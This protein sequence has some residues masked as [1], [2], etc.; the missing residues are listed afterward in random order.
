MTDQSDYDHLLW[1]CDFNLVRGEDSFLRAQWAARPFLWHIYPQADAAH[2]EKLTAFL[3]L[4]GHHLS[5]D[6]HN[7][8]NSLSLAYDQG[9]GIE[10]V[11]A[12]KTLDQHRDELLAS[13]TKLATTSTGWR[14]FS[15]QTGAIQRKTAKI[16]RF[17]QNHCSI[18]ETIQ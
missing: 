1:C 10:A 12:W 3:E 16:M 14:R 11:D 13:R 7:A 8:L 4:Y 17:L 5:P 2:L 15:Q 9:L 6:C 18:Q